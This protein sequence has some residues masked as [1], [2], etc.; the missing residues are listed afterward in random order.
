MLG[1]TEPGKRYQQAFRTCQ[2]S[3]VTGRK[4]K[5]VLFQALALRLD[6]M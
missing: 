6:G 3:V 5:A 4:D 2:M 1:E